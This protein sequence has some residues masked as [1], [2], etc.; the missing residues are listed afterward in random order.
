[1]NCA[2]F[3]RRPTLQ[4]TVNTA[5]ADRRTTCFRRLDISLVC[6]CAHAIATLCLSGSRG[7]R[8]IASISANMIIIMRTCISWFRRQAVRHR[9]VCVCGPFVWN[10]VCVCVCVLVH[11]R[12]RGGS[13]N[14]VSVIIGPTHARIA[15]RPPRHRDGDVCRL[16]IT[17]L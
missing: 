17:D 3:A 5:V 10:C 16:D 4:S 9:C 7:V 1:M 14:T 2:S 15:H 8:R 13:H 12:C 11:V 6:R